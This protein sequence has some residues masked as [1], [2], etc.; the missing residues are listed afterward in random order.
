MNL[1]LL[2]IQIFHFRE[3]SKGIR[4]TKRTIKNKS[5]DMKEPEDEEII[6]PDQITIFDAGA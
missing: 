2:R 1:A 6:D 4:E 5:R 3:S